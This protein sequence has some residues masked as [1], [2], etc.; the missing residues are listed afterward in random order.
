MAQQPTAVIKTSTL[1]EVRKEEE[2]EEEGVAGAHIKDLKE[3]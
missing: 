1:I 3:Y 2:E